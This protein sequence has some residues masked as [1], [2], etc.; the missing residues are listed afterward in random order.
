MLDGQ[1]DVGGNVGLFV[2]PGLVGREVAGEDEGE[3]V[4]DPLVGIEVGA[5]TIT[6]WPTTTEALLIDDID[7]FASGVSRTDAPLSAAARSSCFE[8]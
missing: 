2:S 1:L 7:D 5:D 8:N 3:E 6:C 4:G